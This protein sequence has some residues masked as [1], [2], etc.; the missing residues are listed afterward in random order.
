VTARLPL[1]RTSA[2]AEPGASPLAFDRPGGPLVAVCGLVPGAGTST[3]VYALADQ[4]ARVSA[5]PVLACEADPTAG[6][7]AALAGSA[8]PHSLSELALQVAD[9]QTPAPPFATLPSGLRLIAAIPRRTALPGVAARAV[10]RDARAAHGLVVVDCGSISRLE[11]LPALELASHVLWTLPATPLGLKRAELAL[12]SLTPR[13]P[14]ALETLVAV[15]IAPSG[16]KTGEL[17]VLAERRFDRLLLVPHTRA[18]IERADAD[19]AE[20]LAPTLVDVATL[21]RTSA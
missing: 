19:P 5:A 3:L 10:L 16:V 18:L 20:A 7:L 2:R 15:A 21:L 4:A 6:G 17:R 11:A 9:G 1:A 14:A 13:L 8:S 12:A